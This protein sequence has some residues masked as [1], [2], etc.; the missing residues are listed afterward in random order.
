MDQKFHWGLFLVVL[1]S[2][3][4]WFVGIPTL[5]L[6]YLQ[7][8]NLLDYAKIWQMNHEII[9]V[10]QNLL[11]KTAK[12][13][14]PQESSILKLIQNPQ[15]RSDTEMKLDFNEDH[16]QEACDQGWVNPQ[17]CQ[18]TEAIMNSLKAKAEFTKFIDNFEIQHKEIESKRKKLKNEIRKAESKANEAYEKSVIIL[19]LLLSHFILFIL[20]LLIFGDRGRKGVKYVI[21][22]VTIVPLVLLAINLLAL[23]IGR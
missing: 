23:K 4:T 7:S 6:I 11:E 14:L 3:Y 8:L 17:H 13:S 22:F 12:E 15:F 9:S 20:E 1:L 18:D 5:N 21:Y 16:L 10:T 2:C 19:W